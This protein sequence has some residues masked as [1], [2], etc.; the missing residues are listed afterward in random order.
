VTEGVGAR[1]QEAHVAGT[2]RV[3]DISVGSPP[4]KR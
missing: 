4:G 2:F 1:I 3:E